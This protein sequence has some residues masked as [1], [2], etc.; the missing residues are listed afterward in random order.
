MHDTSVVVSLEGS[1]LAHQEIRPAGPEDHF[2]MKHGPRSV[3][4]VAATAIAGGFWGTDAGPNAFAGAAFDYLPFLYRSGSH[5]GFGGGA[6]AVGGDAG[7]PYLLAPRLWFAIPFTELGG[8]PLTMG[9]MLRCQFLLE[10]A[11]KGEEEEPRGGCGP[12]LVLSRVDLHV[13]PPR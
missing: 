12:S 10:E 4:G 3:L 11:A 9:A 1:V 2:E 6:A 7:G 8:A 5:V 13:S